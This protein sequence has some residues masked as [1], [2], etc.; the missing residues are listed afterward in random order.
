[1]HFIFI[2]Q[3]TK[4]TEYK[5]SC[6]AQRLAIVLFKERDEVF[7]VPSLQGV[8]TDLQNHFLTPPNLMIGH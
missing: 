7:S 4:R 5:H 2:F 8:V 3:I 1:M 6:I